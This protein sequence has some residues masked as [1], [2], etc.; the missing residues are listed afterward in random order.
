MS[1]AGPSPGAPRRARTPAVD[2]PGVT[3]ASRLAASAGGAVQSP[4]PDRGAVPDGG[5]ERARRRRDPASH[6][7]RVG[8]EVGED[9]RKALAYILRSANTRPQSEGELRAKL[10]QRE[11]E[12]G[13]ADEAMAHAKRLGAVDDEKLARAWVAERGVRRGYGRARL[14]EELGRRR[15]PEHLVEDALAALDE[16]DDLAAATELA[17]E[18]LGQLPR[19]LTPETVARRLAAYVTRRGHP[20]ALAQRV[21]VDVSGLRERWD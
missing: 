13:V 2:L 15:V 17:R 5:P 7:Q 10:L 11:V 12:A 4:A 14:R 1:P 19:G 6:T 8:E 20:P 21:A 3:V 16:R 9:V 18:R